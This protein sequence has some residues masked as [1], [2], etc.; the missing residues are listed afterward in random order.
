MDQGHHKKSQCP[1]VA[2][3]QGLAVPVWALKALQ[4]FVAACLKV[5]VEGTEELDCSTE[6]LGSADNL[7]GEPDIL[8]GGLELT[9]TRR[10]HYQ[11]NR[12]WDKKDQRQRRKPDLV[13]DCNCLS[14]HERG[15][16]AAG[17]AVLDETVDERD[18]VKR[19]RR[20]QVKSG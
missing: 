20:C 4:C 7:L 13:P 10:V 15:G 6:V 14:F 19:N 11:A 5:L 12:N 3:G 8:L 1:K 18:R 9:G 17:A 2:V 16:R